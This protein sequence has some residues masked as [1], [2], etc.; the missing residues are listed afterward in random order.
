MWHYVYGMKEA[1]C[2]FLHTV[3]V[4][5]RCRAPNPR[6]PQQQDTTIYAVKKNS[7][8][9]SWRWSKFARNLLNWSWRSINFYC[10]ILLVFYITSPTFLRKFVVDCCI[11]NNLSKLLLFFSLSFC[12]TNIRQRSAMG[13]T[14]AIQAFLS[15]IHLMNFRLNDPT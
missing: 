9:R 15:S 3:N 1:A 6:L 11:K 4:V 13:L 14:M 2:R 12:S 7:V 10:C 5:P 8:L